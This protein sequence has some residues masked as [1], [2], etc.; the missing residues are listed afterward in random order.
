MDTR[1][2]EETTT[3]VETY[4]L[5]DGRVIKIGQERFEAPECMFQPHLVDVEQPGVAGMTPLLFSIASQISPESRDALRNNP[6][7]VGRYPYR[8]LQT[9]RTLRRF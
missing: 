6:S 7:R 8:T 1:L 9:H 4:N 2:A 5:P 3:L